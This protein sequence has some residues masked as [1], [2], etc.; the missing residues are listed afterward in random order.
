MTRD[1]KGRFP[2]GVS[3]N[4]NG[5]PSK[6]RELR[7]YEVTLEAVSFDDWKAIVVKAKEQAMRGD[8]TARAWLG[9]VLGLEVDRHELSG[10][11]GNELIFRVLYGNDST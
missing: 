10:P 5:R 7:F 3:G 8:P 4:P 2:K 9:K 11:G 6:S 1:D